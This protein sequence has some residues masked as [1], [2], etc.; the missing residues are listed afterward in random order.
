M[1]LSFRLVASDVATG[2]KQRSAAAE[3]T[4]ALVTIQHRSILEPRRASPP[5]LP[6]GRVSLRFCPAPDV[7]TV[8]SEPIFSF[9]KFV[10]PAHQRP[11]KN[12]CTEHA[13]QFSV[14]VEEGT[15]G[16]CGRF[17]QL[18]DHVCC[19]HPL[20][21][22]EGK[23]VSELLGP[24][25]HIER[26]SA[27][28]H[29]AGAIIFAAYAIV[30]HVLTL[31]DDSSVS[32]VLVSV[33]AWVTAV[34][35][36]TSSIYHAT[37]PDPAMAYYTRIADFAAIYAAIVVG[38]VADISVATRGFVGMPWTVLLDIPL[39]GFST[40][41]FFG[42]RRYWLPMEE[43]WSEDRSDPAPCSL[44]RGLLSRGHY[45]LQHSPLR[46]ATSL[47][48]A[49]SYFLYTTTLFANFELRVALITLGLQ[50]GSFALIT[51]GTML[52][53]LIGFPDSHLIKGELTCLACSGSGQII[54]AHGIWH[55]IALFSAALAVAAREYALHNT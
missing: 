34:T 23:I 4:Q 46:S 55:L 9:A 16:G 3:A 26:F 36:L 52:D 39:A 18:L 35:F 21:G 6:T 2:V 33:A 12:P 8:P 42:W 41:L 47:L 31:F 51:V 40:F 25:G 53:R 37:A 43:T 20:V 50:L 48:L 27:R 17:C 45:D 54:N 15:N 29:L 13:D 24:E 28:S 19:R 11:Q 30:R 44:G 1:S 7:A 5:P 38:G 14:P 32:G 22:Q 10:G 49:L